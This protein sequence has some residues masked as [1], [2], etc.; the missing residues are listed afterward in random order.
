MTCSNSGIWFY[1]LNTPP[2]RPYYGV[3]ARFTTPD[4]LPSLT[5]AVAY[6]VS[7]RSTTPDE[8]GAGRFYQATLA[9]AGGQWV[10]SFGYSNQHLSQP[11]FGGL[12]PKPS[13]TY[14]LGIRF[15]GSKVECY[16]TDVAA[17]ISY[18]MGSVPDTGS[19]DTGDRP[20]AIM[21]G[22]TMDL[23][24]MAVKP[25]RVGSMSLFI[26]PWWASLLALF[27]I[28][29]PAKQTPWTNETAY[30]Q[31][32]R[33]PQVALAPLADGSYDLG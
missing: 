19:G 5:C 18:L 1:G 7:C 12:A 32:D 4:A 30:Q 9:Y 25:F 33:P 23:A 22:F 16:V 15:T 20:G 27:R 21:E 24:E 31:G 28:Q 6:W 8:T 26:K 14:E 3:S 2:A 13:S 10:F 29:V 17:G 11:P